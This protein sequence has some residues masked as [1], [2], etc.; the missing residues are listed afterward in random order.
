[1][2]CPGCGTQLPDGSRFCTRCGA[3]LQAA[4]GQSPQG[5]PPVPAAR[6]RSLQYEL[7]GTVMQAVTVRLNA[8]ETVWTTGGAMSWMS[9]NMQMESNFKGGFF[10]SIGRMFAGESLGVTRFAPQGGPGEVAFVTRVPGKILPVEL[11]PGYEIIAQKH[12]FLAAQEGVEL[13]VH[14]QR[15]FGA[16]LFGGEGF[17]LQRLSGTGTAFMEV[18]G[19]V[20]EKVLQPGEMIKVDTGH[21]AAFEGSVQ[22]NV[23]MIKGVKNWLLGGEGM[24][25]AT[26]Q[27]PGRIWLQTLP[28]S[29]LV[30]E[31]ASAMPQP[32]RG[33]GANVLGSL[34][35]NN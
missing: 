3:Q 32:N 6:P 16:G 22:M 2:F 28:F 21:I 17:I 5:Q 9:Y 14:F 12:S 30:A 23:E 13:A 24:A 19:E 31:I 33:S 25:L 18:D 29:N 27:G 4:Q 34:L 1:M 11:R 26:L 20:V 15:K 8:G 7:I 35:D 10:K